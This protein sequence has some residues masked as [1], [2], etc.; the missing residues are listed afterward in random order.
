MGEILAAEIV[1]GVDAA[2]GQHDKGHAVLHQTLKP[3]FSAEIVQFFQQAAR[4]DTPQFRVVVA[5]V[6]FHDDLC[7][8]QQAG[9]KAGAVRELAIAVLQCLD[10]RVLIPRL[11]LPDGDHAPLAAVGIGHIKDIPQLVALVR[12]H[13]QG[14]PPGAP[15]NIAAM[16]VPE[17]DLG[18]GGGVRLL[19]VNQKLVA[20]IVLEVV[21]GGGQE[22]HIVPAVGGNF[23]GLLRRKFYNG[24]QFFRHTLSLRFFIRL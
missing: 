20:E 1:H 5:K 21:G 10:Y 18:A 14:D 2:P 6:I 19:C 12:V 16:L 17:V 4:L 3:C 24:V 15:V 22:R 23:A 8:F 13:Q 9:G 7:R 11:H